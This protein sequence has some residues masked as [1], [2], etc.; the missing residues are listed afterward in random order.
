M[1]NGNYLMFPQI[2][3]I[4]TGTATIFKTVTISGYTLEL[5]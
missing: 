2:N 1:D 3:N 5:W 4:F